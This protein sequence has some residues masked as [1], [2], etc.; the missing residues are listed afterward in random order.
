MDAV[1]QW[2]NAGTR[3]LDESGKDHILTT[4]DF[5]SDLE[6]ATCREDVLA[7]PKL[8]KSATVVLLLFLHIL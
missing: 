8:S 3:L 7:W 1:H 5:H 2:S 6:V 4:R